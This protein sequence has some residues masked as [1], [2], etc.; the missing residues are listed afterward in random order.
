MAVAV[1]PTAAPVELTAKDKG[2]K[3]TGVGLEATPGLKTAEM[4]KDVTIKVEPKSEQMGG[5]PLTITCD[6]PLEIDQAKS[7]A[8]LKNNVVAVQL[9]RTLK[10]DRMEVYFDP[11]NKKITQMIC[12]GHFYLVQA[13]NSTQADHAVYDAVTQKVT[14]SGRP[15]LILITQGE[16]SITSLNKKENKEKP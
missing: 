13:G 6:G 12:D 14:L 2:V 5:E 4:Q 16:N 7:V 3:I 10:T 8:V 11:A 9:G 15:K 1:L